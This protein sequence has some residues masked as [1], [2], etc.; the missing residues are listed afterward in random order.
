[1]KI[2]KSVVEL[3][4]KT[5][6]LELCA[7]E[8]A[9][10]LKSRLFAKVELF[11]PAGSI[12]DR[13][14]LS[15]LEGAISSGK[16]KPGGTIIEPTSGNTGIG[17]SMLGAVL[18]YKVIIVMPE[19][20]SCERIKT[21]EAYGASVVLTPKSEGIGGAIKRARELF[22]QSENSFMPMQFENEDNT[23]AHLNTT[24]PEIY[25]D[26]DGQVDCLVATFGTGGTISGIG[27]YLK[28]QNE[29]IKVVGVEP[30]GSPFMTEG[31]SG[32]H[33]IQGIGAGFK[34]DIL[35]TLVIDEI[36]TVSDEDAYSYG[37]MLARVE[38]LLCG[39]SSGAALKAAIDIAKKEENKNI[40]VVLPDS[41]SRYLSTQ[42]YLEN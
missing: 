28:S 3:V 25:R 33:K 15:M 41:G 35:D 13:A 9:L 4:G 18:G 5:P 42:G 39:I 6:L 29:K 27:K 22:E 23:L 12:K 20:L 34:P 40:V 8:R 11:N 38:G 21:I 2:Y 19:G 7:I 10:G 32:S 31:K 16:L 17:L 36:I 1:M 26:M 24:G 37:T 14:A 30:T